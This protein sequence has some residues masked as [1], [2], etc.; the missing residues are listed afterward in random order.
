M[1]RDAYTD[2]L[3]LVYFAK[4]KPKVGFKV[5]IDG[6]HNIPDTSHPFVAIYSINPPG[7]MYLDQ[8]NDNKD[9]ITC[10]SYNWDSAL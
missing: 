9:V 10:T 5:S 2:I 3:E 4:Y 6:F 8:G 1:I 7:R